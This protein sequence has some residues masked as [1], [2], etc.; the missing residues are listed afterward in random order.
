MLWEN[1]WG[2]EHTR[3]LYIGLWMINGIVR[4]IWFRAC[5]CVRL[6]LMCDMIYYACGQNK[7]KGHEFNL[8]YSNWW[9]AEEIVSL[10]AWLLWIWA[11]FNGETSGEIREVRNSSK[12][13]QNFRSIFTIWRRKYQT[14]QIRTIT[15]I[16]INM[17]WIVSFCVREK[18]FSQVNCWI[19]ILRCIESN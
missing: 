16:S 17:I 9:I 2:R 10:C 12:I 13:I 6:R 15:C 19:A 5:V 11:E 4:C 1:V 14:L 7:W 18:I 8:E 3:D